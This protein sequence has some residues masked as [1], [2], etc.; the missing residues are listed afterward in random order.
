MSVGIKKLHKEDAQFADKI[1]DKL[2]KNTYRI[3]LTR[4]IKGCY[5]YCVDKALSNR[6]KLQIDR[7]EE[8]N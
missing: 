7:L 6:F 1:A 3:L 8:K 2:I 4:G 5:I